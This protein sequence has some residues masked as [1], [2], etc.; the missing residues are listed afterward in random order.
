MEKKYY[1]NSE[2]LKH[3][4]SWNPFQNDSDIYAKML[5]EEEMKEKGYSSFEYKVDLENGYYAY[6][7]YKK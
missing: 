6:A 2:N 7:Y 3:S 5:S 4:G 1:N